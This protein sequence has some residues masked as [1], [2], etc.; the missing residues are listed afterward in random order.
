MEVIQAVL[1][2]ADIRKKVKVIVE[3]VCFQSVL[4]TPCLTEFNQHTE[5]CHVDESSHVGALQDLQLF[6]RE[7][8]LGVELVPRSHSLL[9]GLV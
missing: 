8:S 3:K 1:S 7:C 6:G 2:R 5:L 4:L 9:L